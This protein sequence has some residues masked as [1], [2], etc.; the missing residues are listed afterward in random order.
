MDNCEARQFS[1]QMICGKC[2]LQ[3]DVNDPDRPDC[4]PVIITKKPDA[5]KH[6]NNIRR[7]LF[8]SV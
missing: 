5:K 2:G 6:I 4:N 1:D 7:K 8:K 3:W